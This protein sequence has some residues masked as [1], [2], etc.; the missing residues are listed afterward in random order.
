MAEGNANHQDDLSIELRP[1][2]SADWAGVEALVAQIWEGEDYIAQPVWRQWADDREGHLV[3]AERE[4]QIVGLCKLSYL[5]P[6]EW[7]LEGAR[8][9]P[10][11]QR[12]GV[13]RE[14]TDHLLRWF[15]RHGT[16]ILRLS[17]YSGNEASRGLVRSFGFRHIL[18]LRQV[19]TTAIPEDYGNFK[20]LQ[21]QNLDLVRGYLRRSPLRRV[22]RFV[23][24]FWKLYFLTDDRLAE[25]L[26]RPD[27]Q[28]LGWRQDGALCGIA[29]VMLAPPAGREPDRDVMHMGY[30]D[31]LDDTTLRAMLL[32]LRGLAAHRNYARIE[33]KMPAGVGLER[34]VEGTGFEPQW[35]GTLNLY[36]LPLRASLEG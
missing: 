4:G 6:A 13:A 25:D 32:G 18:S 30:I 28:V 23:E 12:Q 34:A 35:D 17:T 24:H 29:I 5:G 31:A 33:W 7:W 36:E 26:A 21:Q 27:V 10:A 15:R 3:V 2:T 8:V 19:A 9:D 11:L 20:L 16:G 14:M 1:G 22:N